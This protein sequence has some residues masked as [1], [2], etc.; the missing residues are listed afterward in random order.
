VEGSASIYHLFN[1]GKRIPLNGVLR[2]KEH[3]S[4]YETDD[5]SPDF[6]L[7]K[8]HS[9]VSLRA[10]LRLGGREPLLR[11]D[12]AMEQSVWY[13]GQYRTD[14]GAYG[15]DG[16]R[17]VNETS[18]LFWGRALF[19]YTF[20]NSRQRLEMTFNA[21]GSDQ[22]DRFSA[23]RL[24]GNTPMTSEFPL[25][26]PGYFNGELSARNFACFN[27]QYA[28]PLDA[29]KRWSL[30]PMGSVATVDY[31]PALAQG[32]HFNSGVGIGVGYR[33]HSG[34]WEALASYGYGFEAIR[35]NGRGGQSIGILLQ[36]DL[37]GR[38]PGGPS[39]LDDFRGFMR[40]QFEH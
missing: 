33:S 27:A 13:E 40:E 29:G 12:M 5:T 36:I 22:A 37:E 39:Q 6:V 26:I 25:M 10:G 8:D 3:Y 21:G 14:S 31:L 35:D 15:F 17:Y 16:D 23:Y 34:V 1:P 4:I 20:P 38:H 9:T 11:P 18:Q 30:N 32:D 19:I 28:I 2:I 7:P 24:G